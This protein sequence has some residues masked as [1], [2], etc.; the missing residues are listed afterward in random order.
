MNA[1]VVF[2]MLHKF[3]KK[4][5]CHISLAQELDVFSTDRE[6]REYTVYIQGHGIE[7]FKEYQ[8]AINYIK[9]KQQWLMQLTQ[10]VS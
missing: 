2:Q 10:P 7:H 9:E 4:T 1:Q 6:Q 8:T 3:N 5:G